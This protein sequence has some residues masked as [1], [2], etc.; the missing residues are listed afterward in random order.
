MKT[1]L[2][3][4]A[5]LVL[6]ANGFILIQVN[7]I[8]WLLHEGIVICL[9]L[10]HYYLTKH[11]TTQIDNIS[12]INLIHS[13]VHLIR[14]QYKKRG[15]GVCQTEIICQ[16]AMEIGV[17]EKVCIGDSAQ[18]ITK[19]EKYHITDKLITLPIQKLMQTTI[20]INLYAHDSTFYTPQA[21]SSLLELAGTIAEVLDYTSKTEE[22]KSDKRFQPLIEKAQTC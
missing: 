13:L 8:V 6:L 19:F 12:K 21:I 1:I 16:Q 3:S 17:F 18:C 9:F 7:V 4:I 2:L 14:K 22:V 20:Y 5:F 10:I 15:E 11:I